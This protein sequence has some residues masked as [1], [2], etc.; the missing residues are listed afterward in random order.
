MT[1][2]LVSILV[3]VYNRQ[4]VL[5]ETIASAQAQTYPS[6]E[7]VVVDNCSTDASWD[8]IQ[9]LA[10]ADARVRAYRNDSNVG[11]VGNWARCF[12]VARGTYGKILFSDDLLFPDAVQRYMADMADDVSFV[13]S[14]ATIGERPDAAAVTYQ[15][16][17]GSGKYPSQA[18][19][20]DALLGNDTPVSPCAALFRMADLKRHLHGCLPGTK[21]DFSGH[22]AGPDVLLYLLTAIEYPMV[23][24]I[25]APLVYFRAHPGSLS[26]SAAT[27]K[28][29]TQAYC[30]T[31]VW[32]GNRYPRVVNLDQL[33]ARAWLNYL[34]VDDGTARFHD[35]YSD[36]GNSYQG[37]VMIVHL[38]RF[39]YFVRAKLG[40]IKRLVFN[41]PAHDTP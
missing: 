19:I 25:N 15:W 11:P 40:S 27:S 20:H 13:F 7:I 31:K 38:L 39:Y 37:K 32:F 35:F 33:V 5:R 2:P 22:G 3:P 10:S 4:H 16:R 1:T 17:P 12:E 41:R 28:K 34:S 36:I 14:A 24:F 29:V 6:I 9:E 23:A 26:V 30:K 21:L 8:I 18:F